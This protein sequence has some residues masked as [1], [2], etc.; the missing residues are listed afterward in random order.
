MN[1]KDLI[2]KLSGYR[3]SRSA[4]CMAAFVAMLVCALTAEAQSRF[5]E[6]KAKD[7]PKEK[8]DTEKSDTTGYEERPYFLLI[9]QSEKAVAEHDYAAAALRLVEAMGIEPDNPLNVALLT[10]LGLIYYYDDQDSMAL[11][12]LN[13]AVERAPK[14]IG[15]REARARVLIG[16]NRDKEAY[17]DYSA[18]IDIDSIN[19]DARFYRGM[20]ALY[21]GDLATATADFDVLQRVVP[22][23]KNNTLAHATLYAMTGRD[24]EAVS[25]FRKLL[26]TD[27]LA[28]YYASL[29]GCLIALDNLNDASQT[30]GEG[31]ER[32]PNDPEL[33]YYRALLN[34]KRYLDDDAHRDAKRAID[35]GAS[36]QRVAEIFFDKK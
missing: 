23:W 11:V 1:S 34:H 2:C 9:D 13:H 33:Y 12:T 14:L 10:N 31:L 17:K 22:L 35:L 36:P 4:V 30:I 28:E 29:A 27:K 19:T 5:P 24:Q 7:I 8:T 32:Y 26:E 15:A 20:M 21:G 3:V 16:M 6:L 25:L 18:I